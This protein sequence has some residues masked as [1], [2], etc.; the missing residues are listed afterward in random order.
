MNDNLLLKC[1]NLLIFEFGKF[2]KEK[3][4]KSDEWVGGCREVKCLEST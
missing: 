2:K 1:K 3:Y 4:Y